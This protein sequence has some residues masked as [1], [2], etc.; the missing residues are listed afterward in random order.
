M[1]Q[2]NPAPPHW[3]VET[4]TKSLDKPSI[5]WCRI[6]LAHH[7]QYQ[8][9]IYPTPS[10]GAGMAPAGHRRQ[11]R[12]REPRGLPVSA[13]AMENPHGRTKNGGLVPWEIIEGLNNRPYIW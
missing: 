12:A 13:P 3:M 7:P 4:P 2:R 6:S 10:S 11:R 8:A 9:Q 5:N 1:G